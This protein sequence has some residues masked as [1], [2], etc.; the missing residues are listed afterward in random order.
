MAN[1]REE[2]G[3]NLPKLSPIEAEHPGDF[4]SKFADSNINWCGNKFK[5]FTFE[6]EF[7]KRSAT[8]IKVAGTIEQFLIT[9]N[10]SR[11]E[12]KIY[13]YAKYRGLGRRLV[14]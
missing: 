13:F 6:T 14:G 5:L 2:K 10:H 4:L 3:L 9:L 1:I 7:T 12:K 8:P 11:P